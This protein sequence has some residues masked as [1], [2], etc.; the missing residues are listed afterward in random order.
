M[1]R[2]APALGGIKV[3]SVIHRSEVYVRGLKP[4]AVELAGD[5]LRTGMPI[6]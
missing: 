2:T 5:V 3:V 4:T 6:G 1:P